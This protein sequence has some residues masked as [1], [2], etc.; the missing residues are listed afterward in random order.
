[1]SESPTLLPMLLELAKLGA[2]RKMVPI[3][4]AQLGSRLGVSQQTVSNHLRALETKGMVE[5][6]RVGRGASVRLTDRG[7]ESVMRIFAELRAGIESRGEFLDFKGTLFT[8][9][10]EGA[11]YIGMDGYRRQ[12]RELLNFDPFPGTL[13]LRL[14]T[15]AQVEKKR[16]LRLMEGLRVEGFQDGKRSYGAAKCFRAKVNGKHV[17]AALVIERTHHDDTVLEIIAPKNLRKV[18]GLS[19]GDEVAV[20]VF[21]S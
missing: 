6:R 21:H 18:L 2:G 8:G 13:N 20:R 17:V 5:R 19:D 9:L 15:P 7:M 3:S 4:S 11:Y 16:E 10:K 1:M 14:D 12:F